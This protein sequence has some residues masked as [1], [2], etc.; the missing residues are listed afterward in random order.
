MFVRQILPSELLGCRGG[1]VPCRLMM[2]AG[3]ID[4]SIGSAGEADDGQGG[5]ATA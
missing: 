2:R 5:P 4:E 1:G 3:L